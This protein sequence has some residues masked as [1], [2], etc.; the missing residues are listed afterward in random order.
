MLITLTLISFL[1]SKILDILEGVKGSI[2]GF[3]LRGKKAQQSH[4]N[5]DNQKQANKQFKKTIYNKQVDER[6]RNTI[7]R[8]R[9]M[10]CLLDLYGE[11]YATFFNETGEIDPILV[12][13]YG[14]AEAC[15]STLLKR[16]HLIEPEGGVFASKEAET[17]HQLRK[18]ER[19][20]PIKLKGSF[21]LGE[22]IAEFKA[23]LVQNRDSHTLQPEKEIK[24]VVIEIQKRVYAYEHTSA[25]FNW[26]RDGYA[27]ELNA[28]MLII[29]VHIE[30]DKVRTSW[31]KKHYKLPAAFKDLG[32]FRLLNEEDLRQ[33]IARIFEIKSN[34]EHPRAKQYESLF[35]SE[36]FFGLLEKGGRKQW[37]MEEA[38]RIADRFIR[39]VNEAELLLDEKDTNESE[40][41]RIQ[42]YEQS[43]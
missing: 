43:N 26:L 4:G 33:W 12:M 31:V 6:E 23:G 21:D 29:H 39:Y 40:T 38:L 5:K 32:E 17:R 15:P 8:T 25:F 30:V 34:Y 35:F 3:L 18:Q 28:R 42:R 11:A 27:K 37:T 20:I 19:I 36:R 24:S 41:I 16:F 10:R 9:A 22:M 13:S 1:R 14:R 2:W 7:D